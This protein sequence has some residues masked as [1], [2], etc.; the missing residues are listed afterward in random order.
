MRKALKEFAAAEPESPYDICFVFI[1]SHGSEDLNTTIVYGTDG[2]YL[3][4]NEIEDFF[5]NKNCPLFK[6][7]PKVIIYQVCRG[8]DLD[9]GVTEKTQYDGKCNHPNVAD[10]VKKQ[11]ARMPVSR[12]PVE[13]MLI[14]HATMQGSKAHRDPF[15]GTWYIELICK[16]FM[17]FAKV[18]PVDNLLMKVDS[19]LRRRV[20]EYNTV[21]TSEQT[22]KGFNKLYLNPGIFEEDGKM[23]TFKV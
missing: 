18:E 16:N 7:K 12:R 9:I 2:K 10:K 5:I 20:S 15:R 19:E 17:E 4:D 22:V 1:M 21:Q 6:G 3:R 23:K 14:G 8:H 13:D 11:T